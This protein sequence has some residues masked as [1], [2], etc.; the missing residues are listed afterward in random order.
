MAIPPPDMVQ[1]GAGPGADERTDVMG[2]HAAIAREHDEPQDGFEPLPMLWLLMVLVLVFWGGYY[3]GLYSETFAWQT[4]DGSPS[5]AGLAK[6][7]T[8]PMAVDPMLLGKRIYNNCMACHQANGQGMPQQFPPLVQ[9]AWVLEDN[10]T[11]I[12]I[13]LHG[14]LGPIEVL[15]KTYNS[16]MPAWGHLDDNSLAAV[17]LYIRRSWGNQGDAITPEMVASLRS[18][19]PSRRTPWS[20]PELE[21]LRAAEHKK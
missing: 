4:F 19:A 11:L 16:V 20:A 5:N 7:A 2:I 9:S 15:G 1:D 21:Q 10:N 6:Q 8:A 17:M 14:L 18:E 13:L 3:L 12:R